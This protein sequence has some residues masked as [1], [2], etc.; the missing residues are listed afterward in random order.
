MSGSYFLWPSSWMWF[1]SFSDRIIQDLASIFWA[2]FTRPSWGLRGESKEHR[3]C[4]HSDYIF[5][6]YSRLSNII[7]EVPRC[8]WSTFWK[9]NQP[10][11]VKSPILPVQLSKAI[12]NWQY[13]NFLNSFFLRDRCAKYHGNSLCLIS[14]ILHL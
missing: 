11:S 4:N 8:I 5:L 14:H 3:E 2:T 9:K 7:S 13:L 12:I 6:T 1:C 10:M